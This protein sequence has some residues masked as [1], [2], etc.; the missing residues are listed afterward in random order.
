[1][2]PWILTALLAL[3]LAAALLKLYLTWKS[4]DEIAQALGALLSQD[5]NNLLFSP[6]RDRHVRRLASALNVQLR[7]LRDQRRRYRSGDRELKEAVT[8]ISHDLRTPLTAICG[9]LDLMEREEKPEAVARYLALVGGRVEAMKLLTEELF[10]YSVVLCGEEALR[11]EPVCLNGAVEE[12]AAGFY[13]ALTARGITPDIRLCTKQVV[14]LLDRG[15][16]ARA[17]GNILGNAVKY[18]AGDLEIVLEETGELV[19]ANTAPGLDGVQVG[20]LFDRFF[21]VEAARNSTG[22]GLAIAKALVERMG[23]RIEARY[24]GERLEIRMRF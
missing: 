12:A 14:R 16:L 7:L 13:A 19:F 18:S 2:L 24:E 20:R 15:A 17:L 6:S 3:A 8:N 21:S 5:T 10:R 23:G 1:M 11:P 4:L 22:L 9:Y